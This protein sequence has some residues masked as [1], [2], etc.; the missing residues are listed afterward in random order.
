MPGV[1][2]AKSPTAGSKH[3]PASSGTPPHRLQRSV[4]RLNGY[5]NCSHFN[6]TPGTGVTTMAVQFT[7]E[8][9]DHLWALP[10][11]VQNPFKP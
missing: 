1:A 5:P 8:G 9:V 2:G 10:E 11:P 6:S 7:G 4:L 3:S